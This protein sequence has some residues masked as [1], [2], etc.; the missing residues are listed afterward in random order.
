[1]QVEPTFRITGI[2]SETMIQHLRVPAAFPED[3]G[4][5]STIYMTANMSGFSVPD[6]RF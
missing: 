6:T 5:T 4:L 2:D 3:L 1:M